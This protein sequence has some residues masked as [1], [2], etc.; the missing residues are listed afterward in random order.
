MTDHLTEAE[1]SLFRNR[2][3]EPEERERIDSHVADCEWCLSR[4][5]PAEDMALA[6]S[7]LTEALISSEGEQPFHLSSA[8]LKRYSNGSVDQA[9]RVIFE[10]H[11]ETCQQCNEAR[12]SLAA[13]GP[14]TSS[15]SMLPD[16]PAPGWH[17]VLQFT[18]ARAFAAVALIAVCLLIALFWWQRRQVTD[19]NETAQNRPN[20]SPPGTVASTSPT[21]AA[22]SDKASEI[23]VSLNDNGRKVE[24]D[25]TGKLN[26]VEDLPE[27]LQS[28]ARAALGARSLQKPDV[29]ASLTAPRITLRDSSAS[30]ESFE[31]LWPIGTVI[32]TNRP[33]LRWQP[34][35]GAVSYTVSVFDNDFNPVGRSGPQASTQW[36]TP[37][38][39]RGMIYSWEVI[40][41]KNTQEVKSPVAPGPR[42]QFR[43]LE[44]A[45]LA[46]LMNLKRQTPVSHLV[47]GL[48]YARFG[49]LVEAEDEF[50]ELAREN[51]NSAVANNLLQSV[52]SWRPR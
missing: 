4:I 39:R 17:S 3:M 51:P 33:T 38:L 44:D 9:D 42:A 22:T 46:E 35:P 6:Y 5:L 24:L 37:T 2:T 23:T 14:E 36:T 18:P 26:G 49:L 10:S 52:Q 43:I 47:L 34:L 40:A 29:L 50:R 41:S 19:N 48:T 25:R 12:Q 16:N 21:P 28:L 15:L 31:Q 45:K 32:V 8:E 11:L 20:Q 30:R 1:V 27:A 7:D 13:V